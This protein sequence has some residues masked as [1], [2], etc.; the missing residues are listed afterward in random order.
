MD[1]LSFTWNSKQRKSFFFRERVSGVVLA[2]LK[3]A[4]YSRLTETVPILL[5][6]P[7]EC[8][9]YRHVPQHPSKKHHWN[10]I[11]TKK[12]VK[13]PETVTATKMIEGMSED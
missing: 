3:L 11:H 8:L 1:Y 5:S 12:V 7:S 13:D 6:L 10:N 2:C 4:I 9:D